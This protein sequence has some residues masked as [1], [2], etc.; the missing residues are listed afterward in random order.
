MCSVVK[1]KLKVLPSVTYAHKCVY[2]VFRHTM[3]L[4][5]YLSYVDRALQLH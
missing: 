3:Q 4:R 1:I 5:L 2:A